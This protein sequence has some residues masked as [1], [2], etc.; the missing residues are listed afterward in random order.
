MLLLAD[1]NIPGLVITKLRNQNIDIASIKEVVPNS[2]DEEVIEIAQSEG[3]IILTFDKDFGEAVFNA[4][5]NLP[6]VI[7][8]RLRPRSP[9]YLAKAIV[10]IFKLNLIW[11]G[12]FSV[13]RESSIR[14][15][16]L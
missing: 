10:K 13:I 5:A 16:N 7:L 12:K 2:S 3:R 15:V 9:D 1:E 4:K 11:Q 6:G 8:I 14:Q